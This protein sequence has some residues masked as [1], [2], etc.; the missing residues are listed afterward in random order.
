MGRE[1]ELEAAA[2]G[3]GGEGGEGGDGEVGDGGEGGAEGGEEGAGSV[4]GCGKSVDSLTRRT[5]EVLVWRL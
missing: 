3:E 2:E 5:W 4:V 1:G